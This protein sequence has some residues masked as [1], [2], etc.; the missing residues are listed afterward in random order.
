MLSNDAWPPVDTERREKLLIA[1]VALKIARTRFSA[2]ST[3]HAESD[4]LGYWINTLSR[5]FRPGSVA[6]RIRRG[7][8]KS[9]GPR[10]Q[11]H[12]LMHRRPVGAGRATFFASRATFLWEI[13]AQFC[14]RLAMN[15]TEPGRDSDCHVVPWINS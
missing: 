10:P 8:G 7:W 9:S 11:P 4:P 1:Y 2:T 13:T 12:E 5:I 14:R 15:W 3:S 6:A